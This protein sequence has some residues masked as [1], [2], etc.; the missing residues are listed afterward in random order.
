MKASFD[1]KYETF[2]GKFDAV[3]CELKIRAAGDW[4]STT[5]GALQRDFVEMLASNNVRLADLHVLEID[6]RD[7]AVIDS[8][9][10]NLMVNVLKQMKLRNVPLRVRVTRRAV[11]L[12]LLSVG[13]ERQL[14]LVFEES[15]PAEVG[16]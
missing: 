10:L 1:I 8:Q 13:M 6:L 15:V 2:E 12:T 3:D 16:Q 4:K 5:V 9:G 14:E 11:Y 7:T